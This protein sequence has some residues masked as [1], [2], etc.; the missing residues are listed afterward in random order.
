MDPAALSIFMMGSFLSSTYMGQLSDQYGRWRVLV[1]LESTQV[2]F[3]VACGLVTNYIA[4]VVLRFLV[5]VST[6][7]TYT[8]AFVLSIYKI[9]RSLIHSNLN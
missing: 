6:G 7:A 9:Y 2:I 3:A 5:S 1:R 4:Y 8:I